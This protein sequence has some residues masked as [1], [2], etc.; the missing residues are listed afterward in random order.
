MP[1]KT[2]LTELCATYFGSPPAEFVCRHRLRL[3][4]VGGVVAR[5]GMERTQLSLFTRGFYVLGSS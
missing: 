4:W 3:V 2:C 5:Q 1:S